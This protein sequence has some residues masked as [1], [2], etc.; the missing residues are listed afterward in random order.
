MKAISAT[1]NVRRRIGRRVPP[2]SGYWDKHN[3]S[4][5]V[6]SIYQ[7]RLNFYSATTQLSAMLGFSN[8]WVVSLEITQDLYTGLIAKRM[9]THHIT[10]LHYRP[11]LI[12]AENPWD[13]KSTTTN[14]CVILCSDLKLMGSFTYIFFLFQ[15]T[16]LCVMFNMKIWHRILSENIL[17]HVYKSC[18]NWKHLIGKVGLAKDA[19]Y[20]IYMWLSFC[21]LVMSAMCVYFLFIFHFWT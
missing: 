7:Q 15:N 16:K 11:N 14:I 21:F 12:P 4:W 10:S 1:C 20:I 3:W 13:S 19:V 8:A 18:N 9:L 2:W 5:T 17:Y 6:P